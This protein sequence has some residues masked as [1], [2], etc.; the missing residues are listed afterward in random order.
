MVNG[1]RGIVYVGCASVA[2]LS[3]CDVAVCAVMLCISLLV[4]IAV[5]QRLSLTPLR[6]QFTSPS[7]KKAKATWDPLWLTWAWL[8]LA[9]AAKTYKPHN[10]PSGRWEG[11]GPRAPLALA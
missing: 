11:I 1:F 5:G 9:T 7:A 8:V 10:L 4:Y 2:M 3:S 6:L